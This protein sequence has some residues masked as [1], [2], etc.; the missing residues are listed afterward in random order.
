MV[1]VTSDGGGGTAGFVSGVEGE[2]MR[3][4]VGEGIWAEVEVDCVWAGS[5]D[6]VVWACV[7]EAAD[8][9]GVVGVVVDRAGGVPL[10]EEAM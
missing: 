2:E 1:V 5:G 6:K 3:V 9:S 10:F 7:G 8:W 4:S